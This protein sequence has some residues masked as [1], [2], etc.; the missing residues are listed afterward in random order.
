M[1][2]KILC[3]REIKI[4]DFGTSKR[5]AGLQLCTEDSVGMEILLNKY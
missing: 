1:I 3:Y 4:A 5:L 2:C